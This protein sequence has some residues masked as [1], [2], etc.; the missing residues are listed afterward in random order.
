[1][2]DSD[3]DTVA[4]MGKTRNTQTVSLGEM[5]HGS[6]LGRPM[7]R[8]ANNVKMTTEESGGCG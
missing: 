4:N 5:K 8:C 6:P 1:M 3:T 2:N 7:S